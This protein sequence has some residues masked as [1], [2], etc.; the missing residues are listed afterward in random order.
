MFDDRLGYK[1]NTD[2]ANAMHFVYLGKVLN[3]HVIPSGK[4]FFFLSTGSNFIC[5]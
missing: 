4:S 2:Q 3:Y 5:L 1:S